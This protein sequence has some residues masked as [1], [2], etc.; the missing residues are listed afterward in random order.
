MFNRKYE[1]DTECYGVIFDVRYSAKHYVAILRVL[2]KFDGILLFSMHTNTFIPSTYALYFQTEKS[3]SVVS[4]KFSDVTTLEFDVFVVTVDSF[5]FFEKLMHEINGQHA[6]G[7]HGK[8]RSK[9][10]V[11]IRTNFSKT[12][13]VWMRI[14]QNRCLYQA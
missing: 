1:S 14:Y 9:A 3:P 10:P 5:I 12:V 8:G 4:L 7:W 6:A 2:P 11:N 13:K